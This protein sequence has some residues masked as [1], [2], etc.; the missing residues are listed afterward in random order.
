MSL[1]T[2]ARRHVDMNR[3][4]EL[5]EEKIKEEKIAE[6]QKQQEDILAEL[7]KIEIKESPKYS[8]WRRELQ[9]TITMSTNDIVTATLPARGDV[10]LVGLDHET[11]NPSVQPG[12]TNSGGTYTFGPVADGYG[13]ASTL[14][15]S[16]TVDLTKVD[17]L[18]FDFTAG[19]ITNFDFV[20]DRPG[21]SSVYSL[22]ISSGRKVITLK[23]SDRTKNATLSWT[24]D[25]NEGEAVGT[26]RI[27]G[28]ALQRR[29]PINVFVPLDDPEAVAFVRGGLGG[30][31]ERK[32]KLKDMLEASNELMIRLGLE[33]NKTS[34][35]DIELAQ[36]LPYTDEDDAFD[37]PYY[38]GPPP[39]LDDDSDFDPND[40]EY[41]GSASGPRGTGGKSAGDPNN[42]QWPRN[43]YPN[44]K[45]PPGPGYRPPTA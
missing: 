14:S 23:Q 40:F 42:I 38:K 27:S 13:F 8:N 4:K 35:G 17:T 7:K 44:K 9:E 37:D 3:V 29:T 28:V 43:K 5:R 41:A 12:A 26:N 6:V 11:P 24:V 20:I 34:P 10:D 21:N 22:S 19:D 39:D 16:N 2:R 25:K 31:E 15:F 1:F 33:P 36:R 32:A 18:V 30:S 45:A